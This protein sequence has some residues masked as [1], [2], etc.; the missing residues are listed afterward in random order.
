M[1]NN[2]KTKDVYGYDATL[3]SLGSEKLVVVSCDYCQNEFTRSYGKILKSRKNNNKDCCSSRSCINKKT[4]ESWGTKY[5]EGHPLK[6]QQI[7]EKIKQNNLE[8]SNE[9]T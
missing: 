9:G 7:K 1:L 8:K 6:N 5:Q 3:L 4:K 2:Q